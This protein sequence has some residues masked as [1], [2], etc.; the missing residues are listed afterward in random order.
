MFLFINDHT[1]M[2]KKRTFH[3]VGTGQT[4]SAARREHRG[5]KR[6]DNP[7]DKLKKTPAALPAGHT[8]FSWMHQQDL[9]SSQD[10]ANWRRSKPVQQSGTGQTLSAVRSELQGYKRFD[11]RKDNRQNAPVVP[12]GYTPFSWMH[13]PYV[14]A[15]PSTAH[16]T[17]W[18]P[19]SGSGSRKSHRGARQ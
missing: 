17:K 18:A 8:P 16:G 5:Y 10:L 7:N 3:Q 19:Q 12:P 13:H 4:I 11:K 6:F 9:A 2:G 15:A 1:N 14:T